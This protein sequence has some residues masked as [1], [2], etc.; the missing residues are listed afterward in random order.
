M[1]RY[2][3]LGQKLLRQKEPCWLINLR[4]SLS[5]IR[6]NL[7]TWRGQTTERLRRWLKETFC[8]QQKFLDTTQVQ[9]KDSELNVS[10]VTMDMDSLEENLELQVALLHGISLSLWQLSKW[11]LSSHLEVSVSSSHLTSPHF[12][13]W[14]WQRFGPTSKVVSLE[15]SKCCQVMAKLVRQSSTTQMSAQFTSQVAQR[16]V[17]ESCREQLPL[18]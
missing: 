9:P 1:P 13:V 6:M 2:T 18:I 17:R 14:K 3:V 8:L 4:T 15:L 5:S 12:P 10:S 16:P 11:R 7:Y